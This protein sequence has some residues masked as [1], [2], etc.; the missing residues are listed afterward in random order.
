MNKVLHLRFPWESERH[1]LRVCIGWFIVCLVV[2]LLGFWLFKVVYPPPSL[3]PPQAPAL[4]LLSAD[5]FE[6]RA[7]LEWV[8]AEDP[9]LSATRA[10]VVPNGIMSSPYR[11]SFATIR[12]EPRTMPE[13]SLPQQYPPPADPLSFILGGSSR[14][15]GAAPARVKLPAKVRLSESLVKRAPLAAIRIANI[16]AVPAPLQPLRCLVGI[17]SSGRVTGA[18]MESSSGNA[19]ADAAAIRAITEAKFLPGNAPVTFGFAKVDWNDSAT[20]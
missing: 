13:P 3:P 9:A 16:P 19:D 6:H 7:L 1:R 12:T 14:R 10:E 4:I 11:T 8:E 15:E 2:H 18:F 17:D 20:P 5:R